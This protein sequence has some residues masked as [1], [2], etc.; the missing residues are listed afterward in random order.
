MLYYCKRCGNFKQR[1]INQEKKC[2]LCDREMY[3]VPAEYLDEDI[4]DMFKTEE[5]KQ[6]FIEQVIKTSPEFDQKA[7]DQLKEN[8]A[9]YGRINARIDAEYEGR[10][11][12]NPWGVHCPYC[13]CTV[14]SR[15]N[16]N[17]S[18]W[19]TKASQVGKQFQCLKCKAYF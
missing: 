8:H 17:Q 6:E 7:M 13:N 15:V 10:A 18:A 5:L 19:F 11:M 9:K 1:Y 2:Y 4:D 3:P 16:G 14:V 12:G